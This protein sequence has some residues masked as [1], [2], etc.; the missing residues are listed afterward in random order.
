[1]VFIFTSYRISSNRP[2]MRPI[3]CRH[4]FS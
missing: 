3:F 1:M 2:H 4:R